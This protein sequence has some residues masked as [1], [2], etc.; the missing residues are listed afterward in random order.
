M[1]R[2]ET[3]MPGDRRDLSDPDAITE[4]EVITDPD[5]QAVDEVHVSVLY[6]LLL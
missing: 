4:P 2:K 6:Y 3:K 5:T 1:D